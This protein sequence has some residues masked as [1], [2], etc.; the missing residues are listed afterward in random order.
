MAFTLKLF[1]RIVLNSSARSLS[2]MDLFVKRVI[3]FDPISLMNVFA[4]SHSVVAAWL[5]WE[6]AIKQ[7]AKRKGFI[8]K[9]F[10]KVIIFIIIRPRCFYVSVF[11]SCNKALPALCIP[12]TEGCIGIYRVFF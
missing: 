12:G 1:S 8:K 3:T 9:V 2:E 7:K 11:I 5:G 6:S 4:F 10:L